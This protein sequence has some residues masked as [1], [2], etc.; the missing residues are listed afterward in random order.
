METE[1]AS[2][3]TEESL[4]L[5]QLSA[6]TQPDNLITAKLQN[7]TQ[8]PEGAH[9]QI[10][11]DGNWNLYN[12]AGV[13]NPMKRHRENCSSPAGVQGLFDQG[14]YNMINGGDLKHALCDQSLLGLHQAK[15]LRSDLEINGGDGEEMWDKKDG[16]DIMDDFPEL[17]KPGE[18]DCDGTRL[19]KRNCN[20]FSNGGDI[21]SL[22]R[23]KQIANGATVSPNSI[24]GT[25][26]DLLEKTL[27]QYYPEQV[28]IAAQTGVQEFQPEVGL[29]DDISSLTN[30]LPELPEQVTTQS[31][32]SLTSGF[33]PISAQMP[34][35]EKHQQT[36]VSDPK[37]Q[38]SNGYNNSAAPYMVNGYSN[39]YREHPQQQPADGSQHQNN[40]EGIYRKPN[41]ELNHQNS[42]PSPLE[43]STPLQTKEAIGFGPGPFPST[44]MGQ[45]EGR[46]RQQQYGM[47]QQQQQTGN[48]CGADSTGPQGSMGPASL[49]SSSEPG[50]QRSHQNG[51]MKD[52][53]Q[54]QQRGGADPGCPN[55][56]MGWIDLNSRGQMLEPD[57]ARRFQTGGQSFD[58]GPTGGAYQQQ[59][60]R[61]AQSP[62]QA[63]PAQHNTAP[64]WQQQAD[65]KGP[66]H[67][68]QQQC[69][70][71][72]QQQPHTQHMH[73][74]Q[75]NLPPPQQQQQGENCFRAPMQPEHLCEGDTD[76]EEILSPS[77]LQPPQRPQHQQQQQRPL[78]HPSQY[79]GQ[80][81][82]NAPQSQDPNQGTMDGQQLLNKLKLEDYIR[83]EKK[84]KSPGGGYRG[85]G[86][87]PQPGH[88][89]Q[90]QSMMRNNPGYNPVDPSQP[91][92][93]QQSQQASWRHS[94]S[95]TMEMEMEL[96]MKQQQQQQHQQQQQR[97]YTPSP[98]PKQYSH[99]QQPPPHLRQPHPNHMDFPLT[100]TPPQPLPHLPHGA[101]NQQVS[102]QQQQ[103]YPKMEQNQ[104]ESCAQFQRGGP[105]PLGHG[106]PQGDFQ[107]HAA[108]RMHLLQRQSERESLG[109][110]HPQSP[111]D[112]K[113][114][115]RP[116][117]MVNGPRFEH[118]H[119]QGPGPPPLMQHQQQGR[120]MGMVA[121]GIQV[122][123]EYNPQPQTS[124]CGERSQSSS[125][126]S[127]LATMEQTLRQYQLSPVFDRKS[128]VIRSPNKVKVEQS[129]AVT[130]LSTHADL[131][132][133][134]G[135]M[136][137]MGMGRPG[138][139]GL[140]RPH[141]DFTPKQEPLLQS[142]MNS[143]MKLL[144]TPI[145]NLLDT[146][147]KTQYDIPS[148]H[149]MESISEKDE[150]P[151]YTHLG[152]APNIKAI[153][154]IME[155]RSG[156]TGSAIR[157][158]KVVY[159]GKEGK[160]TQGCPIA[161]WVIRRGSVDEKLLVLVR[162]RERH[163]CEAACIVVIIL[164]WDGI[165]TTMADQ[166]YMEL[167]DTLTRHGALTQRRC[168]INEERTCACQGL[169]PEA[170]GA[171]FSFGCSWSMYYNGCKFARSK[172]PRKFKLTGDDPKE[173]ER[174]EQNLQNL[175][176][177][178]APTYKTLA[179]DAYQNQVEHE[180]R[181]PDCRLG[182]GEGRP[183][184]GVTACMDFCAHAHRD[185]HNMQGGSTVVCT[186]TKEDNRQIGKIP[187]DEQLHVLPLYKASPTDEF[188]SAE[189]QQEK[190]KTGA[191][192]V[193]N[194]F[195]RQIRMLSEPAKSCRQKKL[196]AK[197]A[198]ASK[199]A[200]GPDTPSKAEK[201]LQAKL[202]SSS[203]YE[204]IAQS[205]PGTGPNPGAM[206]TTP[207]PP[208]QPPG[209]PLGTHL[210]Q[211]QHQNALHAFPGSPHPAS[212]YAGFPNHPFQSTSKPG[213]M[214][215]QPPASA[216]P[217]PS[218]L[219][220][221]TSY[222]NGSNPP[223]SY[224]SPMTPGSPYPGYQ[225]NG[226]S[227]LDNYH[228]YYTSNPKHLDMYRQQR[229][230]VLYPDMQQQYGAHQ[231]YGVN[232]PPQ[233]GEPGLQINGY[234]NCSSMRS[235]IHPMSPYGPPSYGPNGAPDA[236]YLDAL[237]R[238]P[239]AHHPGLDYAAAVSKGNQFGGYPNPYLSQSTK[240]FPPGGPQDPFCMQVKTEMG[241]QS[242]CMT[243]TQPGFPGLPNEHL[244]GG[245]PMIK[246]E[247]RSGPPTPTTPKEKPAMW[248][249]NEH[250]FLD[251]EI[252]GVA[253]APSHGSIL[254]E[255]A[256]REMHATTPLKNPKRNHPTRISLV[257]YQHKNMNEAKHGLALWEAKMAEKQREK[258]EDAE[259]TGAEGAT[260]TPSKS[261][262][263]GAKREHPELSEQQ[264]EP[265]YK[266]FIQ[267]LMERS[268]SCTTNTYVNTSPYAFT[269]VTGPYSRFI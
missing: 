219:H 65:S 192:Q 197:R 44:G 110:P 71:P 50:P 137:D 121:G 56:Q 84:L 60:P 83:L 125:Q 181:A 235:G 173:E 95:N 220:I 2:Q 238:P 208:G 262:K 190:I 96:E 79:D 180:Q 254:I 203:T 114:G 12:K 46:R 223:S 9:Q 266:R 142:F 119:H 234:S 245:S 21:F 177:L 198:A 138:S 134:S 20:T 43:Q 160:S 45:S 237:S 80:Q 127:I 120:E 94:S 182:K 174:L 204:S 107:R 154:D 72:P 161:K 61:P 93:A 193:L 227:P 212:P 188:G 162:E 112:F 166:L 228:P 136:E 87:Q 201:A 205:T 211:L 183:F 126:R 35:S 85:Q 8:S 132:G 268:M 69:N 135:G 218:P 189:G 199:N 111:V 29:V 34:A 63:S 246:Q 269:K 86:G 194:A 90:I 74:Q 31:P 260:V 70:L 239:S 185:L 255:C 176:T 113:H 75:C 191:I 257:F 216:S 53:T 242:P 115:A 101:L 249:D 149:C 261:T 51:M 32:T 195:R 7:G 159:T 4:I 226:G 139:N 206:G 97:Q 230:G 167:S 55:S 25:P 118:P 64:E 5:A 232:Y 57:S 14:S 202:K 23:N 187:E 258:D 30:E 26:G 104:Q 98:G 49:P 259:R 165:P 123:Q 19:D 106:G 116:I 231:R 252:G 128:L 102:A 16:G 33:P 152:S 217:Y 210:Q 157:I 62:H 248:S 143:P 240:M 18:F 117:K 147:I 144:D 3:E 13:I 68:H 184:S 267:T 229:P 263:K 67:M 233:Y 10:N 22:S 48:P 88:Q 6:A 47:Q 78:S 241:L 59:Q 24:E 124:C 158:E 178:M 140:K 156:L 73:Q 105:P 103:M 155:T 244:H 222:M 52:T 130:V 145:K 1:K 251:P 81:S 109:P 146:P 58:V 179:P 89:Q 236:Q 250:N 41:Q 122:K 82:V 209:H 225:C 11:G 243:P 256:K 221:P 163:K 141:L 172:I 148:C 27:S 153:R 186:L 150:G 91:N 15:K 264:G 99:Q 92:D 265:P 39:S 66:S 168:A 200:G 54:Q 77:F 213:S 28:S 196:D 170:C 164:I 169:D 40:P 151:Y 100:Q 214:Y 224:P 108:L 38:G 215:P 171:S 76:L 175:A 131:D 133:G 129:G 17:T 253:V 42:F 36:G 247:P 37:G 207:Q